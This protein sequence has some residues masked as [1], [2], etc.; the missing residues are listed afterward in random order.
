MALLGKVSE[1]YTKTGKG[2]LTSFA[3]KL[4]FIPGIGG[5]FAYP[6]GMLSTIIESAQWL[7]Q[8]KF[9]SAATVLAAGTVGNTV[10]AFVS[11][12]SA[13]AGIAG[14][15]G[16]AWWA[17]NVASGAVT[18]V[19]AGTHA[20]ALTESIIGGVG[21]AL[22]HKPTVL[23][24]YP[25]GVGSIGYAMAPQ[26][27]GRDNFRDKIAAERGMTRAQMDAR[28]NQAYVNQSQGA[29]ALGA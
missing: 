21:G 25:A 16:L 4:S 9:A 18:G 12:G 26:Q 10:N 7:F 17:G 28:T 27:G 22:G 11:G 24:S 8:G 13:L 15:P 3:N 29:N 1:G 19:S 23:S 6:I 5:F 20:R 14:P 2:G